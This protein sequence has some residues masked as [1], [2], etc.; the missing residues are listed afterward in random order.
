MLSISLLFQLHCLIFYSFP[1][2]NHQFSFHFL[3]LLLLVFQSSQ[4]Y[5][6]A[7]NGTYYY[8]DADKKQ[9]EIHSRV[10]LP[11]IP[12]QQQRESVRVGEEEEEEKVKTM[13]LEERVVEVSE[14]M[15]ELLRDASGMHT[16]TY[17]ILALLLLTHSQT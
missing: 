11:D 10:E 12:D 16:C 13:N 6:D 7:E 5:Y 2:L 8:Y 14:A 4:L 17:R 1:L 9:Y 3:L 15:M